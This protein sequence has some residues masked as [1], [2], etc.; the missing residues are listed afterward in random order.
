MNEINIWN[1]TVEQI[2]ALPF[3]TRVSAGNQGDTGTFLGVNRT[4]VVVVAWD[5]SKGTKEPK[6]MARLVEYAMS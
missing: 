6:I 4:G 1:R 5:N 2:K 3:G